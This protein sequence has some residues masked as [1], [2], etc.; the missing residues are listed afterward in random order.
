MAV[1]MNRILKGKV[2]RP[3][4]VV[5]YGFDGV[6]KTG[7]AAGAPNVIFLDANKGSFKYNVSRV[8]VESWG[9]TFEWLTAIEN[10]EVACDNVALDAVSDF[11]SMSHAQ[12]FPG[13]TISKYEGGFNKG[14]DVAVVVET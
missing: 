7:F 6:G 12:L 9:E 2:D 8:L 11:E 3:P 13:T 5:V 1:D 10:G 14:D 4:R